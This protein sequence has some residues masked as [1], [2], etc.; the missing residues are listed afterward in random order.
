MPDLPDP[1]DVEALAAVLCPCGHA[2]ITWHRTCCRAG[3]GCLC[4]RTLAEAVIASPWLAERDAAM[5]AEG[6]RAALHAAADS[7]INGAWAG[8]PSRRIAAAQYAGAWLRARA[9]AVEP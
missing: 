1:A 4:R 2:A 5:R 3:A 7:G 9:E 8:A 6:A